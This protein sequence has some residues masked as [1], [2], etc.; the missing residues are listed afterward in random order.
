MVA[1]VTP[2]R[3][4][5]ASLLLVAALFAA[6]WATRSDPNDRPVIAVIGGGFILNYRIADHFYGF[7]AVVRKPLES[8]SIIEATFE[9][10]AGGPDFV[11]R[12][13]VSPMTDRYDFRTPPLKG[14][15][16]GRSYKVGVRVL[17]REAA[18]ELYATE[19]AFRSEVGSD[20][21]PDAPLTIGP[22]YARNPQAGG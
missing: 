2:F 6:G 8:G 19:L 3:L 16:A 13:R 5:V 22:G 21:L 1:A 11:V 7:T 14:I 12:E 17:D 20:S 18:R 15:E 10:P 4:V 9:D